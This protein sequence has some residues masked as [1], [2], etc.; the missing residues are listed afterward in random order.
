MEFDDDD[1][2]YYAKEIGNLWEESKKAGLETNS[3]KTK[4]IHVKKTVNQQ[5]T[6]KW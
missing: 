6:I 5:L 1:D 4:E 3:S 2:A